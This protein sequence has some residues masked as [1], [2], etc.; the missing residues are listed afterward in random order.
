M[1]S[2]WVFSASAQPYL[3]NSC[4]VCFVYY[5]LL[6]CAM[7]QSTSQS[8]TIPYQ[9]AAARLITHTSRREHITPVLR[10]L[11]WLPV[12]R[13]GIGFTLASRHCTIPYLS[14][15]CRCQTPIVVFAHRLH[16]HVS[17]HGPGLDWTT[18]PLM[19]PVC[20]SETSCQFPC[21]SRRILD[22]LSDC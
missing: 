10:K 3:N 7:V 16:C 2:F 5:A 22:I 20:G 11:H 6:H 17:C 14:D 1:C 13:R 9:N 12:R 21:I 4:E 8:C 15:E 18:D 19:S